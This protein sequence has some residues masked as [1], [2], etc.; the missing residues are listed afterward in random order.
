MSL[1]LSRNLCDTCNRYINLVMRTSLVSNPHCVF[2]SCIH[3]SFGIRDKMLDSSN[4]REMWDKGDF[5]LV[6]SVLIS[7]VLS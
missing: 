4:E 3:K 1:V 5:R 6:I 7:V 2:S